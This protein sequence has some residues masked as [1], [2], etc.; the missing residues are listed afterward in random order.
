MGY[1]ISY[2]YPIGDEEQW[3]LVSFGPEDGHFGAD[4]SISGCHLSA[5]AGTE[6]EVLEKILG[7]LGEKIK[8]L[9]EVKRRIQKRIA[10]NS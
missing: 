10:D 7:V 5:K 1:Q 3:E 8:G 2:R 4:I 9:W 6:Q